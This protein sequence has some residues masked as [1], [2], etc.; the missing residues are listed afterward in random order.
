MSDTI[1]SLRKQ[2]AKRDAEI[3]R[4][5]AGREVRPQ[6]QWLC[7]HKNSGMCL[8]CGD[9][10]QSALAEKDAE[11]ERLK[12]S[13]KGFY[14]SQQSWINTAADFQTQILKL[15][16]AIAEY[17]AREAGLR[18]CL[19]CDEC[20]ELGT[21]RYDSQGEGYYWLCDSNDESHD[22]HH[23]S[24]VEV[25]RIGKAP[26]ILAVVDAVKLSI[27]RADDYGDSY[28]MRP[29]WDALAALK[30]ERGE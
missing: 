29:I 28:I 25:F 7:G 14:D 19:L 16:S 30:K 9:N 4:L 24:G 13:G 23:Y 21:A 11:I 10:A 26:A 27:A 8:I 22:E 1:E 12:K 18:E 6:V 20:G 15:E 5:S 3:K 17:R 2:L